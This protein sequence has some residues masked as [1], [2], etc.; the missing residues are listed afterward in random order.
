MHITSSY[1]RDRGNTRIDNDDIQEQT[2]RLPQRPNSR[3]NCPLR[4]SKQTL[5][6]LARL[7]AIQTYHG[8]AA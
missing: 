8:S 4:P 3:E 7:Q 6:R 5:R 1:Y 2:T